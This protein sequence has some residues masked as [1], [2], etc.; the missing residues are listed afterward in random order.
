MEEKEGSDWKV[1]QSNYDDILRQMSEPTPQLLQQLQN[2]LPKYLNDVNPNCLRVAL[3]IC[4]QYFATASSINYSQI[5][6]IL[7]DKSFTTNKQ[8]NADAATTLVLQCIRYSHDSVLNHIYEELNSKSPKMVKA[9]II[10]LSAYINESGNAD[11]NTI[12]ERL[13]PLLDHR[14]QSIRKEAGAAINLAKGAPAKPHDFSQTSPHQRPKSPSRVEVSPVSRPNVES[15]RRNRSPVHK[16]LGNT[17]SASS[18]WSTW[19]SKSTLELLKHQKWQSVVAGFEELKKAYSEENGNPS[20]CVYGLTTLFI[21]RTFTPKVMHN[22]LSDILFYIKEDTVNITDDTITAILHFVIDKITDKKLEPGVFEMTDIV[23]DLM[24]P[25][26]VFQAFYQHLTAKNYALPARIC[27]YFVHSITTFGLESKLNPDEV[28][29]Q[30]KPLCTHSDPNVRKSALECVAALTVVFGESVLDGFKFLKPAQITDIRKTINSLSGKPASAKPL[31]STI[32]FARK[33]QTPESPPRKAP[34]PPRKAPS[35]P[36]RIKSDPSPPSETVHRLPKKQKPPP[37]RNSATGN[38][39]IPNRLVQGI[40]KNVSALECRKSLDEIEE[41][42]NRSLEL[43]G[44]SSVKQSEFSSLFT[45]IKPWFTDNNT[46]V[47]ASIAKI[48]LLCMKLVFPND[49]INIPTDFLMDSFL[50]L[51]YSQ[52]SIRNPTVNLLT[53]MNNMIPNFVQNIFLNVFPKMSIDGKKAAVIFI[54]DLNFN[55]MV[56]PFLSFIISCMSDKNEDFKDAAM[57]F[58][59]RYIQLPQAV[60]TIKDFIESYP[61]AKKNAILSLL[62]SSDSSSIFIQKPTEQ[63]K[64]RREQK[65]DCYLPLK[66]LNGT[67]NASLLTEKLEHFGQH[68]F[69]TND[70]S[71]TDANK[72]ENVCSLFLR[73]ADEDFQSLSLTL[74]IVF[75]WWAQLSLLI[76]HKESFDAIFGFLLRLLSI[77]DEHQ[78]NLNEFELTLILPTVLECVGRQYDRCSDIQTLVFELSPSEYLLPALV[79]ILGNVKS[80]NAVQADFNALLELI[81]RIGMGNVQADLT[82]TA[83]KIHSI[84]SKDPAKNPDLFQTAEAFIE[85][86][87]KNG[88][89]SSTLDAKPISRCNLSPKIS[90]K[91]KQPSHL[92]YQWIVDLSSQD[93]Q[94]TIQAL[95]SISQQLKTE[96]K[97]FEPHLDALIVSLITSVHT[98]FA[99]DPPASRLCKYIAFCLLT[100]FNETSLK[101]T[102]PQPFVQ[103]LV[104]EMLTHLSNGINE[105]VLNQ[106]LNALIVKLINDCTMFAF[107]GLLSAIGEFE[108]REQYTER[109]IRLALKCFEACG[110]RICEVKDEQS[111]CESIILVNKML[112][113]YGLE[114]L[115]SSGIGAKIVGV[116]K[117]YVNLVFER[118]DDVVYT[119]EM[120]KTLGNDAEIYKLID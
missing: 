98:Y 86:L 63:L 97:V 57:P 31:S 72:I 110:V 13:T 70:F 69:N 52:K 35:P 113:K 43:R 8:A 37:Q 48:L 116:L 114:Q 5:A 42:L 23:C 66:V 19:V 112:T 102:I 99:S 65:I 14:D 61:P 6:R 74:D 90:S 93:T 7:V 16:R 17:Q 56:Q 67:E 3:S 9:M 45:A 24:T 44:P 94:I 41:H 115:E 75:L 84:L 83:I 54:R 21:G 107:I 49:A 60:E 85:F 11:S 32:T 33:I 87:K 81:P 25:P 92:V 79:Y 104:Y 58:I 80:V 95:K 26:Y 88:A 59:Q 77:M 53:E 78:R 18:T 4:E 20:A 27:S 117:S 40:S 28:S 50:L 108:N 55:M 119:K 62:N 96:P 46:S 105:A 68:F 89:L 10:L 64:E 103:Q 39:F 101:D 111:I 71:S 76:Q 1:R 15:S 38:E 82:K 2:D 34:S 100:L 36:S 29:D 109:W 73:A 22:L 51:N 120:K 47:V 118:F 106:V 91:L 12:V 30:I